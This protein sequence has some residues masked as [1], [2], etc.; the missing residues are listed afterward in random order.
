MRENCL[1]Q[2]DDHWKCL[3][4]SNHVCNICPDLSASRTYSS[5]G[6]RSTIFAASRKGHSTS[7]CLRSSYVYIYPRHTF[8][9]TNIFFIRD[10]ASP[11]RSLAHQQT[12]HPYMR[13]RSP[14]SRLSKSNASAGIFGMGS[15]YEQSTLDITV[16]VP[17]QWILD[18]R[19]FLM[20]S[21][22]SAF[23]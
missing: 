13:L 7:A 1:Q 16:L 2:F 21:R 22:N 11:R 9:Y 12:R 15:E 20:N 8:C 18:I 14:Y 6:I 23:S 19:I 10:R 4:N 5:F 17:E 3:E